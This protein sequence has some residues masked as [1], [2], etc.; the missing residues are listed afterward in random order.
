MKVE[1]KDLRRVATAAWQVRE[2]ARVVGPTK[3]GC[4][5][6]GAGGAV[7][8]GCNVEHR[9]RSHDI[10]AETNA[11]SSMVSSGERD[12]RAVVVVADHEQFT[13]CGACLDWIFEFGGGDC[14]V[15]LQSAPDVRLK[16]LLASELM[17][18]YPL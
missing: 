2:R 9:Y 6:L 3:V 13:P 16:T 17:P 11:I 5:V 1:T 18:Y 12:L 4:A 10:H 14:L 8:Q 7:Y 15:A